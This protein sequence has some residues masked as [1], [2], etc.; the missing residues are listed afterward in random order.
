MY[1]AH[2]LKF[3]KITKFNRNTNMLVST[4]KSIMVY[5]KEANRK[6][7]EALTPWQPK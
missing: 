6:K 1:K 2:K 7:S 5:P 3:N 4:K